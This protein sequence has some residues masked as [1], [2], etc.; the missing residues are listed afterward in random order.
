MNLPPAITQERF[1]AADPLALAL[2]RYF[3]SLEAQRG[4][5]LRAHPTPEG[6]AVY[7]D[8]TEI[9]G[10]NYDAALIRLAGLLLNKPTL[11]KDL[12]DILREP[13]P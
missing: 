4:E 8:G 5:E 13:H 7:F 10:R 1:I 3:R 9:T 6:V 11:R 2:E 12:I